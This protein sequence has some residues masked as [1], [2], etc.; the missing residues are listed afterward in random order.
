MNILTSLKKLFQDS[1]TCSPEELHSMLQGSESVF[2][3]DVRRVDELEKARIDGAMHIPL[4][5]LEERVEELEP[6]RN[7]EIVVMCHHGVRSRMAQQFLHERGFE[8]VRNLA[9]GIAA[10]ANVDPSVGKY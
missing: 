3:L 10:Y 9:G 5:A 1:D 4:H 7:A 8:G 2:L 6:W